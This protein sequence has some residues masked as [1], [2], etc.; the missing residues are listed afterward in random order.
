MG[1]IA[2]VITK[3]MEEGL[4][5]S[6]TFLV[7]LLSGWE[8]NFFISVVFPLLCWNKQKLETNKKKI[9]NW[10]WL[11]NLP[12][13]PTTPI[14]RGIGCA[15]P[16]YWGLM[17]EIYQWDWMVVVCVFIDMEHEF[18]PSRIR[19]K[20]GI[21]QEIIQK[22]K[23]EYLLL[24]SNFISKIQNFFK[25]IEFLMMMMMIWFIVCRANWRWFFLFDRLANFLNFSTNRQL[26]STNSCLSLSRPWL[27]GRVPQWRPSSPPNIRDCLDPTFPAHQTL[28][29]HTRIVP[30][31]NIHLLSISIILQHLIFFWMKFEFFPKKKKNNDL[32]YLFLNPFSNRVPKHFQV[33]RSWCKSLPSTARNGNRWW[34]RLVSSP[35]LLISLTSIL[36]LPCNI[37]LLLEQFRNSNW[38]FHLS[39]MFFFLWTS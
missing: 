31:N 9:K 18:G 39:F 13:G 5:I 34:C 21:W 2:G 22:K 38:M 29:R 1:K 7:W 10:Y 19:Q 33:F 37:Q 32:I 26:L 6:G 35:N 30:P 36:Q 20:G 25:K 24:N 8:I 11:K 16:I 3:G 15:L 28:L 12:C 14:L 23:F 27:V 4:L 17:I